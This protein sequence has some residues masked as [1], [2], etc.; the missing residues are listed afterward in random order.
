MKKEN[1]KAILK[2]REVLATLLKK[3]GKTV[4]LSLVALFFR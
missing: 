1:L 2:S 3:L 4:L